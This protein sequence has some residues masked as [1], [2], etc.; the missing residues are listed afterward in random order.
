MKDHR[1][2]IQELC[3]QTG[4]PRRTIHFYVQQG[5]LPP[6]SGAGL[7]AA[8]DENHLVR[9]NLIPILR[10]RGLRLDEIRQH[11][12]A[13]SLPALRK[14][15][16]Q[17][18]DSLEPA[19]LPLPSGRSYTH[20]SLPARMTLITPTALSQNDRKRLAELLQEVQRIWGNHSPQNFNRSN[21]QS[22]RDDKEVKNR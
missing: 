9:L 14:M 11:F 16:E 8:Y 22:L 13:S 21:T 20:Y 18:K 4:L 15:L 12:Q 2:S 6:P 1:Y 17:S 19:S 10:Q 3:E 7:S 5:I